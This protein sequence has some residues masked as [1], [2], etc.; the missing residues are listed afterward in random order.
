MNGDPGQA[1]PALRSIL[2]APASR[3]DV[4]RKLPRSTPDAAVIDLEDAVAPAGKEEARG[5]AREAACELADTAP[6][7]RLF[8]RLNAV[9]TPWFEGDIAEALDAS[10]AGVVLPKYEAFEQLQTLQTLLH[11]HGLDRL[12]IIAGIETARGV[13]YA[14]ELLESSLL[15][16][17][18]GA[19]DFTADLGGERTRAGLE[20][21]YAR[22]RMA[23]AARVAGVAAIDQVV[24]DFRDGDRFQT[25]CAEARA[26]GYAGKLCI[27]P[28][29]VPL[30]NEAFSPSAEEVARARAM[31]ERYEAAAGSGQGVITFEGQMID[32][33]LVAR[34]QSLL[35]RAAAVERSGNDRGGS[36]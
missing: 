7:L 19:E 27:H 21:L 23:V 35:A 5:L 32:A 4:V 6:D 2:F 12:R 28:S 26:L 13:E 1:S 15:A 11:K 33:P 3:P 24:V 31:L 20:V 25:E 29:Q 14:R 17:Y 36:A 9:G 34:A 18:F 30:A 16:A 10:L 22:S 8:V